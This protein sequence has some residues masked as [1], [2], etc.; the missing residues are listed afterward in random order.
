M[1][2]ERWKMSSVALFANALATLQ[3]Y[4]KKAVE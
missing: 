2:K 4:E 3:M 1:Q